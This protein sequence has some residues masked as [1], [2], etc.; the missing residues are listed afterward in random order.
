MNK[1][2]GIAMSLCVTACTGSTGPMG[3][4]GMNGMDGMN[5]MNGTNGTNGMN[6]NDV[7]ISDRAKHGL[8]ISPV[9]VNTTGLM[10]DQIEAIGQ[11]SYLVNAI[12]GCSDCHNSPTGAFL[13]GGVQFPI[14][15][16]GDFVFTRNLTP[17]AATGLRLTADQFV[18][19]IRTGRDFKAAGMNGL[20]IVMPWPYF[21]WMGTD[22]LKSIYAYLTAIPAVSNMVPA[23]SKGPAAALGPQ[24]FGIAYDMG[25]QI[26]P[27]PG[28]LDFMGNPVPD[29]DHVIRGIAINALQDPPFF[30]NLPPDQQA[31]FGRGSYLIN[32][33]AGCNDC[34]GNPSY[35]RIPGAPD[36]LKISTDNFLSGG[37]VFQ[38]PPPLAAIV[39]TSRSMSKNLIGQNYGFF[40]ESGVSFPLFETIITEGLHVD[41]P[42]PMPLAWPMPWQ[43]FRQ[44]TE[45]DLVSVYTYL[46]TLAQEEPRAGLSDKATQGAAIYCDATH[47]CP[48]A[49]TCHMGAM[50]GNE[51]V[52]QPCGADSDCGACQHCD[53][54]TSQCV[55]PDPTSGIDQA[56]VNGGI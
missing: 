29:D 21:R 10:A 16:S 36:F 28:E 48:G 2:I 11:G 53:G 27:L 22:D 26:R 14:D 43:H 4:S 50:F 35:G 51:C 46:S 18:E 15:A 5:G 49:L 3:P 38:T 52:G 30:L 33:I 47:A 7:I 55:A 41:D 8:D 13:G 39:G 31:R 24:A 6:G 56:C 12:G 42:I 45:E 54:G 17:D 23:D 40:N 44:M 1:W 32:S 19:A 37:Q 20:L 9:A 34:H 25:E